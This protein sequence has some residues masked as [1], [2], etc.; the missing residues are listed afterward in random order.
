MSV[1]LPFT[2]P[3]SVSEID[4]PGFAGDVLARLCCRFEEGEAFAISSETLRIL[5]PYWREAG[6]H[7]CSRAGTVAGR[8][9]VVD[10]DLPLGLFAAP[11]LDPTQ[12]DNERRLFKAVAFALRQAQRNR[13][14]ETAAE[15]AKALQLGEAHE[16]PDDEDFRTDPDDG[17]WRGDK[18]GWFDLW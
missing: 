18:D 6:V 12:F 17:G 16:Y 7:V 3:L 15:L 14:Y 2:A 11:Q 9:P 8:K 10:D 5:V 4:C 1:V 13:D